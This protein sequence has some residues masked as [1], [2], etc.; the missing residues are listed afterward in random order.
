MEVVCKRGDAEI[1][2]N[3]VAIM[4]T[5][6]RVGVMKK[7]SYNNGGFDGFQVGE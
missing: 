7:K 2:A 5:G 6:R 3:L 1:K 4:I